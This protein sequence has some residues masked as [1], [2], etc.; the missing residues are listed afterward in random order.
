MTETDRK[1]DAAVQTEVEQEADRDDGREHPVPGHLFGSMSGW[2]QGGAIL[3]RLMRPR[4][5][6][7]FHSS[8]AVPP[9]YGE[10]GPDEER[11]SNTSDLPQGATDGELPPA[12]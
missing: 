9:G 5:I 1:T 6:E 12:P 4:A 2:R 3:R 8:S 10:G 11:G 7:K